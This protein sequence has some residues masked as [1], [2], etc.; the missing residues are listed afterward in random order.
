M[1]LNYACYFG[2][3]LELLVSVVDFVLGQ[4]M[5]DGG[6]NC[7]R[8]RSGARHSSLHSTLS[9]LEG[10]L[11]YGRNGCVYRTAEA[12]KTQSRWSLAGRGRASG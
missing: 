1:F 6:F 4:Q 2:A 12:G 8:N 5:V 10:I 7:Q 11:A 3:P 9:V